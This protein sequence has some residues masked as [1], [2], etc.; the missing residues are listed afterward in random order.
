[1]R[2][3]R[4]GDLIV[5]FYHSLPNH[6]R[7]PDFRKRCKG[8][9]VEVS[10]FRMVEL[11]KA[12]GQL[13]TGRAFGIDGVPSEVLRLVGFRELLLQF[14]VD[15]QDGDVPLEVLMTSFAGAE[16][17]RPVGGCELPSNRHHQRFLETCQ[18][19]VAKQA[20]GAGP[21]AA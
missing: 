20:E 18:P 6:A 2:R 11:D 12:V 3:G 5:I 15:Y 8:N 4:V 9:I 10:R 17:G 19:H 7:P 13:R 14:A 1:M 16:E 21:T